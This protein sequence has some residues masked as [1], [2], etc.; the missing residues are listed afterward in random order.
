MNKN[1]IQNFKEVINMAKMNELMEKLKDEAFAKKFED[2]KSAE[3]FVAVA[4]KEGY[5]VTVE[6]LDCVKDL[7]DDELAKA[8]GGGRWF[9]EV[10]KDVIDTIKNGG[11]RS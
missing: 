1:L 8:A 3:D 4:K 2:C 6:D 7:S 10:L 11:R 5:D 9:W